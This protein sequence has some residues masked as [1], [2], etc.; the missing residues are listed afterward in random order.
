M[1]L[2]LRWIHTTRDGFS[3]NQMRSD[4]N[5]HTHV[6][7]SAML[8]RILSSVL[9]DIVIFDSFWPRHIDQTNWP[10][11]KRSNAPWIPKHDKTLLIRYDLW[12][13]LTTWFR[14]RNRLDLPLRV[15]TDRFS[16][17]TTQRWLIDIS[18]C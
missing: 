12:A 1:S 9:Q 10:L 6:T 13:N 4:L 5:R 8:W 14:G 15:D 3:I 2:F 16:E 17:F 11:L 18:L 7:N